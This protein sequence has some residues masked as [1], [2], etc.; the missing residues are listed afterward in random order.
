MSRKPPVEPAVEPT[1]EPAVEP[2]PVEPTVQPL[3]PDERG[4]PREAIVVTLHDGSRRAYL[5]LCRHLPVPLDGGSRE[6]LSPDGRYLVC[7]THGARYR[8][9]DGV[10]VDGPC[11]GTRLTPLRIVGDRVVDA[12]VED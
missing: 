4:R 8:L 1:A 6:F 12:P 7:G 3:A 10:C 2:P 5:N 11:T 9:D